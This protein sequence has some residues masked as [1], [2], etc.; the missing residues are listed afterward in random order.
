MTTHPVT[1]LTAAAV[2]V[3]AAL[4]PALPLALAGM[5]LGWVAPTLAALAV[6]LLF[7]RRGHAPGRDCES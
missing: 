2:G 7:S 4:F 5:G 3:L 1:V 6:S